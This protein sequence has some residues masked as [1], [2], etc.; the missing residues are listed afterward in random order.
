MQFKAPLTDHATNC[1]KK[2]RSPSIL[3]QLLTRLDSQRFHS[4]GSL[5]TRFLGTTLVG[6]QKKTFTTGETLSFRRVWELKSKI[7][8]DFLLTNK[9]TQKCSISMKKH[10]SVQHRSEIPKKKI[11]V[12]FSDSDVFFTLKT[13]RPHVHHNGSSGIRPLW[14]DEHGLWQW[15]RLVAQATLMKMTSNLGCFRYL[16]WCHGLL[17]GGL[18]YCLSSPLKWGR[19]PFWLIFF[20]WVETTN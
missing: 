16:R 8:G 19:F 5:G 18:K 11:G 20:K 10:L 6:C 15:M 14:R 7:L 13:H 2:G 17:A 9:F 4:F 12:F 1:D 3:N